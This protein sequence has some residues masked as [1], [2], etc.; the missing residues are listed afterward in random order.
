MVKLEED[1]WQKIIKDYEGSG[2]SQNDFCSQQGIP[3]A[4]FKYRWRREMER[5]SNKKERVEPRRLV[6]V[7]RFE[8]VSILG[9][10]SVASSP[11]KSSI[12]CIQFPNQVRCEFEM[13]VSEPE[14]GLLL[15]QLVAL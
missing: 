11:N 7:P 8:E 2:L 14:L 6:A 5:T 15:K 10:D 9:S 13:A 1:Y 4:Q 3:V 12:I